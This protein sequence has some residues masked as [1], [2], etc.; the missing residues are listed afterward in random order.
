MKEGGHAELH[1]TAGDR[2]LWVHQRLLESTFLFEQQLRN[3]SGG[4]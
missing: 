3:I 1:D 4:L 2:G